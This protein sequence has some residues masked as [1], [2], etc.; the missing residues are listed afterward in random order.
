MTLVVRK[1]AS[2]AQGFMPGVTA[3]NIPYGHT[4]RRR[5]VDALTPVRT[6]HAWSALVPLWFAEGAWTAWR[7]HRAV[8]MSLPGYVTSPVSEPE[9]PF[10]M[11]ELHCPRCGYDL[12]AIPE[13]RCP[14]CGFA[15]DRAAIVDLAERAALVELSVLHEVI[16]VCG[17]LLAAIVAHLVFT[18]MGLTL[19]CGGMLVILA[20]V[21]A[22][23]SQGWKRL[24]VSDVALMVA[25]V[26]SGMSRPLLMAA[27]VVVAF[28]LVLHAW[29]HG[30]ELRFL[31]AQAP[32]VRR[33]QIQRRRQT[34]LYELLACGGGMAFV[35]MK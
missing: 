3:H 34:I 4:G 17:W 23:A 25:A 15:Y 14:E 16:R 21:V 30:R 6:V 26:L 11:K 12:R 31:T 35:M 27:C 22:V 2:F 33:E 13:Y 9:K 20:I 10:S 29:P 18:R 8:N 32:E 5:A 24:E 28:W 7:R 19:R 1:L